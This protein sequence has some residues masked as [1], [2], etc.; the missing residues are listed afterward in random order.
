LT[1]MIKTGY[2][3]LMPYRLKIRKPQLYEIV[4][5]SS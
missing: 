4:M 2:K 1:R 5:R 3:Q